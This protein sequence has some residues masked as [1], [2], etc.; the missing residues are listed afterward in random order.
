MAWAQRSE[1]ADYTVAESHGFMHRSSGRWRAERCA[2]CTRLVAGDGV[3]VN[4]ERYCSVDC[5]LEARRARDVPGQY[6]G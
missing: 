4:R 3:I 2:G 6:L 5:V 1:P